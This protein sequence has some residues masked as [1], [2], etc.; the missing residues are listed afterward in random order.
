MPASPSLAGKVCAITGA[1]GV[2]CSGMAEALSGEGAR[3]ALIGRTLGKLEALALRLEAGG[4]KDVLPV[5]ADVLARAELEAA[6]RTIA[7]KWGPVQ[8]LVNGAGGNHPGGTAKD[9]VLQGRGEEELRR[10]VFGLDIAA[11]ESVFA[12]NFTGTLL[13]SLVFGE[14]MA[15][16][17]SGCI[18]NLSSMAAVRPLTKVGAYSAAKAAVD[19]F[20]RWLAV[21]LAPQG[22]R[23]NAIAPGFFV[24]EQNRFL[25][26]QQDGKTLTPRGEKILRH[27]PMG[28]FGDAADLHG[29][30]IYLASDAARFLTG[31]VLPVD[32]GFSAFSGV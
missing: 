4:C 15:R 10:G 5:R 12:L 22:I 7:A 30:V 23:V 13:P 2:L 29:A 11:V 27:T 17:G 20:T 28:R 3:L 21:H 16:A 32:G 26:Y 14:D 6:R 8:I 9:E 19:N 18:I 25:L 24:T 1:A 31:V